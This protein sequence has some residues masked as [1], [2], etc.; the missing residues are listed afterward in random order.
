M[1]FRGSNDIN[2]SQF[3]FARRFAMQLA[4]RNNLSRDLSNDSTYY[5]F[6][7]DHTTCTA[8]T[9]SYS[10]NFLGRDEDTDF[11]CVLYGYN[12]NDGHAIESSYD[13]SFRSDNNNISCSFGNRNE[14][15]CSISN[16]NSYI[17]RLGHNRSFHAEDSVDDDDDVI[18]IIN[19]LSSDLVA[20]IKVKV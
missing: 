6:V 8:Y 2:K 10:S 11:I 20:I 4:T 16:N 9:S 3:Q 13:G 7:C 1:G 14:E 15:S 19:T 12:K 17:Y 5:F 18:K